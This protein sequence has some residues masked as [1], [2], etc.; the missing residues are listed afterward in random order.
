MRGHQRLSFLLLCSVKATTT[1]VTL[2]AVLLCA[3]HLLSSATQGRAVEQSKSPFWEARYHGPVAGSSDVANAMAVDSNTGNVY[4]TGQSQGTGTG[5]DFATVA[6]DSHGNQLWAARYNGSGNGNDIATAIA[7]NKNTGIVYVTGRSQGAGTGYDYT[8]VAYDFNGNQLWVARYNGPG[9][10]DDTANA[11]AVNSNTG[12]IYV[13]GTSV[14]VSATIAYDSGGNQFW[15]ARYAPGS[16]AVA[17]AVD[18]TSENVYVA[19]DYNLYYPYAAGDY[20]AVVAYDKMGSQIWAQTWRF[21]PPT[22]A[23]SLALDRAGNIYVAGSLDSIV[24]TFAYVRSFDP[25][26]NA[27][28]FWGFSEADQ[29]SASAIAVDP[30]SGNVYVMGDSWRNSPCPCGSIYITAAF[31]S[32][33]WEATYSEEADGY[34]FAN[35]IAVDSN[36]GNVYITGEGSNGDYATVAYDING[37]QL[38]VGRYGTGAA[39]TIA[40]DSNTGNVYVTGRGQGIGF[41]YDFLTI[42]YSSDTI[43]PVTSA[44]P[45]PSPNGNGWDNTSVTVALNAS[46]NRGGSG[47]KNIQFALSGAQ[48]SGLKAV[49][50]IAASVT[51]LAEGTT[52]L[53]YFATDYAGNEEASKSLVIKIDKT[54]PVISG[55]PVLG[56]TLWPPNG[57]LVQVATVSAT[58]ALSG[59]APGSFNVSGTSN[60]PSDPNN[61]DIVITPNS[62]G[63]YVVQLRADRLGSGTGRVYTLNATATD[64]AGNVATATA[65][66]SVPHDMSAE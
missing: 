11:I 60:E 31:G 27:G 17:I 49:A 24:G 35:A 45:I 47:V 3:P 39:N 53:S 59:L 9:N 19:G 66:C 56:C 44:T 23:T 25:Q 43:P 62:S 1:A 5:Y 29:N 54:P 10:G 13:T 36:T 37:N 22:I 52:T 65:T 41:G 20:A 51:I 14:G 40:V 32:Q 21:G 6:Y 50:G 12:K 7:I 61:P 57:K 34:N 16:T 64:L 33:S 46:D 4:V 30:D 2:F 8:T 28:Q 48:K 38:W 42:A 26:G 55:L 58:D 63:G 15:V 18:M